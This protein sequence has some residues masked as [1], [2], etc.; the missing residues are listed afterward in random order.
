[1]PLP[2][3]TPGQLEQMRAK[4]AETRK[5]TSAALAEVRDG[6]V[7]V[8]DALTRPG[9]LQGTRVRSLLLAAPGIGATTADRLLAGAG[10]HESRRRSVR[11]QGLGARQREKLT[12]ALG[13]PSDARAA[14]D[15]I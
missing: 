5:A 3:M 4:A 13:A 12:A 11:V 9:P 10:I 8:A 6:T 2:A 7:P 1:M 14:L 15:Y